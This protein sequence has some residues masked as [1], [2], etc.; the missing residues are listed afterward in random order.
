MRLAYAILA[1]LVSS[2]GYF[3]LVNYMERERATGDL[4]VAHNLGVGALSSLGFVLFLRVMTL[5][6]LPALV[7]AFLT[8]AILRRLAARK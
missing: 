5:F 7:A 4:L 6:V 3:N 1:L 2:L 8:D